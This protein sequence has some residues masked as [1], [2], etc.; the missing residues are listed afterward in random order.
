MKFW[1]QYSIGSFTKLLFIRVIEKLNGR[2]KMKSDSES[3]RK[4]KLRHV[5]LY[6]YV[7]YTPLSRRNNNKTTSVSVRR[8]LGPLNLHICYKL[9]ITQ[10]MWQENVACTKISRKLGRQERILAPGGFLE[11]KGYV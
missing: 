9:A 6:T 10:L 11:I 5:N 1:K 8:C 7:V 2:G 3:V 4:E